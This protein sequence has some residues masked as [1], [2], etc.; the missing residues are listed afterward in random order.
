M[1]FDYVMVINDKV[2][3]A[4]DGQPGR[5]MLVG[6]KPVYLCPI[7]M[8][9]CLPLPIIRTGTLADNQVLITY[10]S[11]VIST[12][13]SFDHYLCIHISTPPRL[14]AKQQLPGLSSRALSR[15]VHV[16]APRTA[17]GLVFYTL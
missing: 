6:D 8:G 17:R 14:F 4:A 3:P 13:A 10:L 2:G 16:L 1:H 15:V 7:N 12:D 5:M 9:A 11:Y